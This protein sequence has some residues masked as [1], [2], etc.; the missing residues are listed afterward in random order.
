M[1]S[2]RWSRRYFLKRQGRNS[3]APRQSPEKVVI[4]I[5]PGS[6]F[7]GFGVIGTGEKGA[8]NGCSHIASGKIK[9]PAKAQLGERLRGLYYGLLDAIRKYR[10][11]EAAVENIFFAKGVRAALSLGHARGVALLA[12][13]EE[14]VEVFEYS[15]LEVKKA[16]T[17]YG[18]AEKA[19]VQKMVEAM[20][21]PKKGLDKRFS[22][23]EADALALALCHAGRADFRSAVKRAER[24]GGGER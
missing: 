2:A 10:P 13:E 20:L 5:D 23:D 7:C 19:Q 8:I 22:A 15:A 17:G 4:G 21:F 24:A 1:S 18:M 14:G 6:L 11:D 12:L 9:L 16:V 3:P